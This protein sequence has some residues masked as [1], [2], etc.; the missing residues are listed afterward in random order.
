MMNKEPKGAY[1]RASIFNSE[2]YDYWKECMNV[3]IQSVNMDVWDTVVNG[4]FE[5]Q[6]D[7]DGVMQNKPKADW[8]DDDKKMVQ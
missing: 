2:N 6:D 4:W 3:H 5:P 1:N 7:V 8:T